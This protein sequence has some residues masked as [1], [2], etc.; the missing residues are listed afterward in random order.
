MTKKSEKTSSLSRR[1]FLTAAAVTVASVGSGCAALS[2]LLDAE[3]I[4][5]AEEFLQKHYKKLSFDE[6][7]VIFQRLEKQVENQYGVRTHIS[8][9][10]PMDGVEFAYA[11]I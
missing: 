1:D 11:S 4:P 5:T 3:E 10:P 8:D 2:P 6:K 9:P 7:K